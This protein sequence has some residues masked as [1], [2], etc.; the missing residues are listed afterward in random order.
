M[1][2]RSY[3]ILIIGFMWGCIVTLAIGMLTGITGKPSS[4]YEQNVCQY[5]QGQFIG[6]DGGFCLINNQRYDF[7]ESNGN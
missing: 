2:P 6:A 4:F 7:E 5:K 3:S 1:T